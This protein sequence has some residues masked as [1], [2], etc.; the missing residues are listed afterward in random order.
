MS[1]RFL[2]LNSVIL[3]FA[4]A[5]LLTAAMICAAET[6]TTS[7]AMIERIAVELAADAPMAKRDDV[8]A[9]AAASRKLADSKLLQSV[10]D[11]TIL[12][13]LH[14]EGKPIDPAEHD[15]TEFDPRVW[16]GEYLSEFMFTGEHNI[17]RAGSYTV[18]FMNCNFRNEMDPGDYPYPFWHSQK[19]WQSYQLTKK[20]LLVFEKGKLIAGFRSSDED[21]TRPTVARKFDGN[22]HWSGKDNTVEPHVSLYANLFSKENPRV[23]GLETAYRNLESAS[24]QSNCMSCHSPDNASHTKK[25]LLLNFPNQ[26]LAARHSI[27]K[28]L[29]SD[30]MPPKDINKGVPG[31]IADETQKSK[32]IELARIFSEAADKALEYENGRVLPDH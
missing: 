31:G 5:T 17:E 29:E 26:A 23:A 3:L 7:A 15:V 6:D 28:E 11:E 19:K 12:C 24:R 18:L 30:L 13:G 16:R 10:S 25:L 8:M 27:V 20:L 14:T 21:P 9:Y 22:W 32:M 1:I 2:K 4:P